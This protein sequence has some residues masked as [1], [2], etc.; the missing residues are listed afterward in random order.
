MGAALTALTS[1]AAL[2]LPVGTS[3]ARPPRCNEETSSCPE[4]PDPPG[5]PPEPTTPE[6]Q[7]Q[8]PA[9][10]GTP[11]LFSYA[12]FGLFADSG[13][14][15]KLNAP[16]SPTDTPFP[17]PNPYTPEVTDS[18]VNVTRVDDNL[19]AFVSFDGGGRAADCVGSCSD[20][21]AVL[22]NPNYGLYQAT[23]Q[24]RPRLDVE[25]WR[26][27]WSQ[28][29]PQFPAIQIADRV[30]EVTA[31]LHMRAFAECN[32]WE[33]GTA[34][35]NAKMGLGNVTIQRDTGVLEDFVNFFL[36]GFT[37]TKNRQI[38]DRLMT[39]LGVGQFV[40]LP[41]AAGDRCYTLGA[42]GDALSGAITW[43]EE[44]CLR[45]ETGCRP[46]GVYTQ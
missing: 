35:L 19:W 21:P 18:P 41:F 2:S 25:F 6:P 40:D 3:M 46:G 10:F 9:P 45:P 26:V 34:T 24:M 27:I 11:S 32:G 4:P 15:A 36:P 42:T 5:G 43:N 39:K 13:I 30:T 22:L 37:S 29:G 28:V 17:L 23:L 31:T 20:T 7:P 8:P 33:L 1:V 44:A 38:R 12:D 16:P 14:R